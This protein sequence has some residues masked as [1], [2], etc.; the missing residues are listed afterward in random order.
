MTSVIAGDDNGACIKYAGLFHGVNIC[1]DDSHVAPENHLLRN[2]VVPY[3]FKV[4]RHFVGR[5]NAV[6]MIDS[7]SLFIIGLQRFFDGAKVV[8]EIDIV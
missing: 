8:V 5:M 4:F 1:I 2:A 6:H 3:P 7:E